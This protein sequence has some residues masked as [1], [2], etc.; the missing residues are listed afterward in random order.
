MNQQDEID[1]IR[2]IKKFHEGIVVFSGVMIGV[3]LSVYFFTFSMIIDSGSP[4]LLYFQIIT[5]VLFV[6]VLFFLKKVAFFLTQLLL[7]RNPRCQILLKVLVAADLD[8]DE[9]TLL[10]EHRQVLGK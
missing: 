4:L 1:V 7:G 9:E 10:N 5:S 8:K 2:K 6:V 3:I